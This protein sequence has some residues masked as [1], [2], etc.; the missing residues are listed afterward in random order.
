MTHCMHRWTVAERPADG[1]FEARCQR[2]GCGAHRLFPA[3]PEQR[4][5]RT[6]LLNRAQRER[7]AARMLGHSARSAR[8][9]SPS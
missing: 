8:C 5:G 2:A 6:S 4:P 1:A 7:A 9:G 3:E